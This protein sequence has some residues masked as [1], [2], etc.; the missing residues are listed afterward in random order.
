M[1]QPKKQLADSTIQ[2]RLLEIGQSL[3]ELI[4]PPE[5]SPEVEQVAA[6]QALRDA[7]YISW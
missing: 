2:K 6:I 5:V 7:G 4:G 1:S 3:Q